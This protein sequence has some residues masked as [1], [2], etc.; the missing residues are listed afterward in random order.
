MVCEGKTC[1]NCSEKY[2]FFFDHFPT[3]VVVSLE[4]NPLQMITLSSWGNLTIYR[5]NGTNDFLYPVH[6]LKVFLLQSGFGI[7]ERRQDEKLA[8]L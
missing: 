4:R 3:N 1:C 6:K 8:F 2:E 7:A 5:E